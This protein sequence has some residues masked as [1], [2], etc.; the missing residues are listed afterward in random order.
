MIPTLPVMGKVTVERNKEKEAS[1]TKF[2]GKIKHHTNSETYYCYTNSFKDN[3]TK[4]S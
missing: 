4:L 2:K 1:H 3:I